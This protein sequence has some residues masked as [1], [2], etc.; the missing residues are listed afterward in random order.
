MNQSLS[1]SP[2]YQLS[3]SDLELLRLEAELSQEE[4]QELVLLV[5]E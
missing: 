1:S 3:S 5:N 4:I 2:Q